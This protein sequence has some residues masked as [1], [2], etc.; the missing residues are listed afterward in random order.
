MYKV[1]IN[2]RA[3]VLTDNFGDY[4]STYD[5]LYIQYSSREGF[6]D[7]IALLRD[8][9]VVNQLVVHSNDLESL[10]SE[11]KS[12]YKLIEAAGGIVLRDNKVLMILKNDHWDLPKGKI[13]GSE[14]LEEAAKR[15]VTEECGLSGLTI[16]NEMDTTYYIF[17]ENSHAVLKKT[18]WF[19][20]KSD[21]DGPLKGDAKEGITEVLWVDADDWK[22]KQ[23]KSYPSVINLLSSVF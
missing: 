14:S 22:N 1:F 17:Q 7:S 8:S 6:F 4:K 12:H 19:K 9:D 3:I 11:F 21:S 23:S 5:T 13:D 20:M 10:W 2:D 18:V 15:E 16:E